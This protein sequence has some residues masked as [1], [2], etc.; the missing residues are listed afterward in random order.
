MGRKVNILFASIMIIS[1]LAGCAPRQ[2]HSVKIHPHSRVHEAL[3]VAVVPF[4][5]DAQ[6]RDIASEWFTYKLKSQVSNP[7]IAPAIVEMKL[8]Q[9]H[10]ELRFGDDEW[11]SPQQEGQII[12]LHP[13]HTTVNFFNKE[14]HIPM[15]SEKELIEIGKK[16]DVDM[17]IGGYIVTRGIEYY[18]V[19]ALWVIDVRNES[20]VAVFQES[21]IRTPK[22]LQ[23]KQHVPELRDEILTVVLAVDNIL[24]GV[25]SLFRQEREGK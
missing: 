6:V 12:E 20:V 3:R 15:F 17:V 7:I 8:Q 21:S 19:I 13:V 22:F 11:H 23:K 18:G 14:L 24:D 25:V 4:T 16:L 9:H 10:I 2:I 1:I 5:G